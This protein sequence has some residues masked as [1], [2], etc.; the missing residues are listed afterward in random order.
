MTTYTYPNTADFAPQGF[1]WGV[2]SNDREFVSQLSGSVQTVSLPG[3][4]WAAL[5]SF[6]NQ[7]RDVRPAVEAFFAKCRREHRIALWNLSRPVPRGSINLTGVT[8]G[9]AA[10]QFANQLTLAGCGAAATIKAGDM[11]GLPGQL[12]MA[13]ADA[14]AD[15]SGN[16]TVLLTHELRAAHLSGAAVTLTRPTAEFKQQSPDTD[17]P[18]AGT[19]YPG[20]TV[21]LVEVFA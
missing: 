10:A 3:T 2:R 1:T 16:M 15:G 12:L 11:L 20:M 13:A 18:F 7:A 14:T 9:A 4:R 21:E 8:L 19:H 6:N 17:F 5:L